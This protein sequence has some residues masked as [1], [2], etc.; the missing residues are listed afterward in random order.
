MLPEY[1]PK[2]SDHTAKDP[3]TDKNAVKPA[4]VNAIYFPC[5]LQQLVLLTQTNSFYTNTLKSVNRYTVY[6]CPYYGKS[7]SE[8]KS[9]R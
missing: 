9:Q 7:L 5:L 6:E 2:K 8:V 4:L 3:V 1:S